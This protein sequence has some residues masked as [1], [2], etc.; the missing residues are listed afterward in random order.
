MGFLLRGVSCK[1]L[2]TGSLSQKGPS[3]YISFN[4]HRYAL[5][6]YGRTEV[7]LVVM[8]LVKKEAQCGMP[9]GHGSECTVSLRTGYFSFSIMQICDQPHYSLSIGLSPH[10]PPQSHWLLLGSPPVKYMPSQACVQLKSSFQSH[11]QLR[12]QAVSPTQTRDLPNWLP[13][14]PPLISLLVLLQNP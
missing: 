9:G 13:P 2:Q 14:A 1:E 3:G 10:S 5:V 4:L 11:L 8:I 12:A 7:G 6:Y